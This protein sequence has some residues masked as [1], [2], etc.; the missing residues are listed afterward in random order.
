M[1]LVVQSKQTG[2][3]SK[4]IGGK[5]FFPPP[6]VILGGG[7]IIAGKAFSDRSMSFKVWCPSNSQA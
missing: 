1:Q 6:I 2:K 5:T 3:N 7:V 4:E